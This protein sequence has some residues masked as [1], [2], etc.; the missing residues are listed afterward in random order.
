MVCKFCKA[1]MDDD[2]KICPACGLPQDAEEEVTQEVRK[3]D[4]QIPEEPETFEIPKSP[5]KKGETWKLVLLIAGFV[6]AICVLAAVLLQAFGVDLLKAQDIYNKEVYSAENDK[7]VQN[8]D[9]VVA[10]YGDAKLTNGM[11][12]I[13]FVEEFNA[14]VS[15]YYN[16]FTYIGL[17]V[18]LPL[19]EQ[20]S[21]FD[22]TMNWEQFMLK[23]A[24]DN[25]K[26]YVQMVTLAERNGFV[27]D[28]E[29][30]K[31]LNELPQDL[32]DQAKEGN[33]VSADALL[34][35]RYGAACTLDIYLE[36][37][38]MIFKGNAFYASNLEITDQEITDAFAQYE[39]E[40]AEKGITKTSALVSSVR[41]ILIEPEGG[42]KSE[43]GKTTTYSDD[44]WAACLAKAEDVLDEWTTG[45]ATEESFKA[46]VTKYT[47]DTASASTGGLYEGVMND[48]SYMKPFQDWAIDFNRQPGEV[49][50][51]KTDYGYH[52][53]YFVEG[54]PEWIYHTEQKLKDTRYN[55]IQDQLMA[56]DEASPAKIKY[57]KITLKALY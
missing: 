49:G 5:K 37:A 38:A 26:S 45:D 55:E 50:L 12:Q 15:E 17:D 52:I 9:T 42:T 20:K 40:F 29:W 36:Y 28:E 31:A 4:Q 2:L 47:A 34:R 43:D 6:A 57:S 33:L 56:I 32:E 41:H 11:L 22:E 39:A 46:L 7:V 23:A 27:L 35:D 10:T 3:E 53:M 8:A 13:F 24:I 48:G 18:T 54:E 19:S 44:E 21:Y 51:V 30:Q 14:F 1:E 25:W 16:Y